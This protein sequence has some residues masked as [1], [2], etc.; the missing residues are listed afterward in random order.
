MIDVAMMDSNDRCSND[1]CSR[2]KMLDAVHDD[3]HDDEHNDVH[4]DEHNLLLC[5]PGQHHFNNATSY[6]APF[7]LTLYFWS[8]TSIVNTLP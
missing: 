2:T 4:D 8:P 5:I 6:P 7:L 3:E 1:G